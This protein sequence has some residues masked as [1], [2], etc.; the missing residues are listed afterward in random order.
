MIIIYNELSLHVFLIRT[1]KRKITNNKIGG[2][3]EGG[4]GGG[5]GELVKGHFVNYFSR[6]NTQSSDIFSAKNISIF[7]YH[8]IKILTNR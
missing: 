1:T 3:G 5:G 4:G 7:A 2:S 6:F 8:S